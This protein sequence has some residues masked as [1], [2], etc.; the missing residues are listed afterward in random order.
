MNHSNAPQFTLDYLTDGYIPY[1]FGPQSAE[2][3]RT[4]LF[5]VDT[6]AIRVIRHQSG[7]FYAFNQPAAPPHFNPPAVSLY[8]QNAWFLDFAIRPGGS[9]VPQQLWFPQG[10]GDRRHYMDQ[11][12]FRMPVFFVNMDGSLGVPVINAAAGRMQLRGADLP[13]QFAD[14]STIK[15]RINVCIVFFLHVPVTHC[16]YR[17]G[18]A[19]R[20]PNSK[21]N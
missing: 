17:S 16:T 20:P 3:C 18:R 10:Q 11:A 7:A 8:G 13:P 9:I 1:T 19:M 6:T 12:R 14:K 4:H 21:Y 15:I 5:Y 2:V